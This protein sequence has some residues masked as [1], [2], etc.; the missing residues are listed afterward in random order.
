MTISA[1]DLFCGAG[2]LTHGLELSGIDVVA[3]F[4]LDPACRYPYEA[5]NRAIFN[6]MDV[7]ELS[8]DDLRSLW[9]EG[10][11]VL[12]GCAPCQTFSTYSMGKKSAPMEDKRYGLIREFSRLALATSPDVVSME[13]VPRAFKS[14][15]F[16]DM[17]SALALAGYHCRTEVV[18][19]DSF[20]VP[21]RRRRLVFLASLHG[22]LWF[23]NVTIE[24]PR[25]VREAI[26]HLEAVLPGQSSPTDRLHRP[27]AL[28]PRNIKRVQASTVGGTWKDWPDELVNDCHKKATGKTYRSV[29]GRMNYDDLAPT[30]T[31]LCLGVGN[32]RFSHPEQHRGLSIR[33]AS[34][35]QTFPPGYKFV[36]PEAAVKPRVLARL[37]GNAVPVNLGRAIGTAIAQHLATTR[38]CTACP[39]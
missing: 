17:I 8:T 21:Q 38:P 5:N 27:S 15:A 13:N 4:D 14:D 22:P 6:H 9:K 31:T 7:S 36:E 10:C 23:D 29:Y 37:I 11:R 1:V 2:G 30:L 35:L 18:S 34:L 32:G 3:G 25:S 28:S 19:C 39:S 12:V 20:G 33:E 16:Q 24:G 26:G